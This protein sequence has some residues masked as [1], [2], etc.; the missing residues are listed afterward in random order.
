[1]KKTIL[2]IS[3]VCLMLPMIF[4]VENGNMYVG[5]DPKL[6]LPS[7]DLTNKEQ[8]T[9]LGFGMGLEVGYQTNDLWSA[10][11]R[12]AFQYYFPYGEE[13]TDCF[14]IPLGLRLSKEIPVTT[15]FSLLPFLGTGGIINVTKPE[16]RPYIDMGLQLQFYYDEKW[17]FFVGYDA[18]FSF[19]TE[20]VLT[21][22]VSLG[23]RYYPLREKSVL[24]IAVTKD[25]NK[26]KID[27]PAIVF[28]PNLTTFEEQPINIKRQNKKVLDTVA[29]L[30]KEYEEYKVSIEAY[31]NAVLGTEEEKPVLLRLSQGRADTVKAEL[32]KRGIDA[33]RLNAVGKGGRNSTDATANRRA[34]FILEK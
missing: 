26:I 11:F 13:N 34:E 9:G 32:I 2:A 18:N 22:G 4:A 30:L 6:Q 16:F 7:F 12:T 14:M 29:N 17:N 1:M 27:V 15:T 10:G 31:A 21:Q 23:F 5:I 8:I 24:D 19:N 33:V 28:D 3:L 20:A 25:G